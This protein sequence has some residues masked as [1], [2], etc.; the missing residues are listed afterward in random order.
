MYVD[1]R[2]SQTVARPAPP[3]VRLLITVNLSVNWFACIHCSSC[4]PRR[5]STV[6]IS[7]GFRPQNPL[8]RQHPFRDR[9][10]NFRPFIH[11][12]SS[13]NPANLVMIGPVDVQITSLTG[14]IK[15]ETAAE[16]KPAF[17]QKPGGLKMSDVPFHRQSSQWTKKFDSGRK[18]D[19]A[20][21]FAPP[22]RINAVKP[23]FKPR[24]TKYLQYC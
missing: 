3:H 13:T 17:S 5:M 15:K 8:S 6:W 12:H 4:N 10:T 9:K 14:I 24:A 7:S 11:S 20:N 21:Y 2:Q 18:S 16:H 23:T 1:A 22:P 19:P